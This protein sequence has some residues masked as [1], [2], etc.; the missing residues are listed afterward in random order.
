MEKPSLK[1]CIPSELNPP[2]NISYI[3]DV[4]GLEKVAEFFKRKSVF[5]LDTETNLVE[6]FF[7]RRIR[8][9][10]VGDR[11]EQ[12]VVDLLKFVE[13][14]TATE[15]VTLES[16]FGGYTYHPCFDP[17]IRVF[18]PVLESK[19]WLKVG[20]N[21][22]FDYEVL[23]W[24][25]GIR[26][27][28]LY[29]TMM[30]EQVIYAGRY[31]FKMKGFW[32]LDDC[33]ARYC[34]LQISKEEQTSFDLVSELTEKQVVYC[35]L[36]CRL[37]LAVKSG[38]NSVITKADLWK[39]CQIEFDAIPAFADMHLN[40]IQLDVGLWRGILEGVQQDHNVN[41]AKL[42]EFFVPVVGTK[43]IPDYDL[44]SL[45]QIWK[46]TTDKEVRAEARKK[47][48]ACRKHVTES[49][50]N[51]DKYEGRAAIN[52]GSN[53]QLLEA[54]RKLGFTKTKL[55]DTNDRTLKR[56]AEHP[57]WDLATVKKKDPDYREIGVI[58]TLRLY[59]ETKKILT[60]YGESFIQ[61][62]IDPNTG[63]IHSK[64]KQ[65]GAA[66]GRTSSTNPNIQNIP[67]GSSWRGCFVA[68]PGWKMLT[69][70]YNGCELRILAEYSREKVFLD[71]FLKDWDVHSLGAEILF[72]D[73]WKNA[74]EPGCV[75]YNPDPKDGKDHKKCKCKVHK[76][77]RD[78]VKALNFGIAYGMEAK[79]LAEAINKTEEFAQQLLNK[80]RATFPTLI[81]YLE[82]SAKSATSKMESR[83]LANRRRLF[84]KPTWAEAVKRAVEDLTAKGI[85][86]P[87]STKKVTQK[88]KAMFMAIEREG[89][90]TPIQ[91]TNADLAKIAMGCGFDKSGLGFMW[92]EL[93]PKFGAKL[94][95][96]VHDEFVIEVKPEVADEC[97]KYVGECMERSGKEL[98]S[99][100]PMTFEGEISDRWKK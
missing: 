80:Y 84:H 56:V 6:S 1:P 54:L 17:I 91:G 100:I 32:A 60:T 5:V 24:C 40:G 34:G 39:T 86:E 29:D 20:H 82:A 95:N 74:A 65:L 89:K 16:G 21:L 97:F 11:E 43:G 36:D 70:D 83:T 87:P 3:S 57:M 31:D 66:T 75:Y 4:A 61:D 28:N 92:H 14:Y 37:P 67:R 25:L 79:K 99:L 76:D 78:S 62:Y 35:A 44:A 63:R 9:I 26:M 23:K 10:Q 12:Y 90:N 81:K 77:L 48:M 69:M 42:D 19:N 8:T 98:I 46:T 45:E 59:R 49:I 15:G 13:P 2:L 68:S 88:Y 52:Y 94:V 53:P 85:T 47:F 51:A 33:V 41:V 72:G 55:P 71:A 38:Q 27:W 22:Q 58:D 96:F 64:I 73:E 18:K 93:E 30:A 7:F 50:K